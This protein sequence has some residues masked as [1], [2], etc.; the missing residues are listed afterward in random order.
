MANN[1]Q[2]VFRIVFM[3]GRLEPR[4]SALHWAMSHNSYRH[5]QV[6]IACA[7]CDCLGRQEE[8][9]ESVAGQETSANCVS[10]TESWRT[11]MNPLAEK[12]RVHLPP[13][14]SPAQ[15]HRNSRSIYSQVA[16]VLSWVR[17]ALSG[18]EPPGDSHRRDWSDGSVWNLPGCLTFWSSGVAHDDFKH[19]PFFFF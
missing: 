12:G 14:P 9:P 8:G 17:L 1:L 4:S 6:A 2:F 7:R 13:A 3:V 15:E 10:R 19:M 18:I 11:I 16:F 5:T